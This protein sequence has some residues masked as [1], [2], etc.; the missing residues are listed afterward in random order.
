MRLLRQVVVGDG[1][2]VGARRQVEVDGAIESTGTQQRRV[3]T[4]GAVGGGEHQHVGR[5]APVLVHGSGRRHQ[6]VEPIDHLALELLPPRREVEALHLHE[7]FV[8]DAGSALAHAA[9]THPRAGH[10]DGVELFDEPDRSAL[11]TSGL[12]ERLEELADLAVGHAIEV[13]LELAGRHE[14]ERHFGLGSNRLRQVGLPGSGRPLEQHTAS[15]RATH[16]LTEGLVVEEQVERV[17]GL[18]TCRIGANDIGKSDVGVGRPQQRVRGLSRSHQ[19]DHHHAGD[20][21]QH[22]AEHRQFGT[23]ADQRRDAAA[24]RATGELPIPEVGNRQAERD[25]QAQQALLA[26]AL[27]RHAGVD[28]PAAKQR[29]VLHLCDVHGPTPMHS[30]RLGRTVTD[31]HRVCKRFTLRGDGVDPTQ[32]RLTTS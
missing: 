1:D 25:D 7:Q 15:W 18:A 4:L 28:L 27:S 17:D 16:L 23:V 30:W 19:R 9:V 31:R 14:Q 32:D 6:Q 24:H 21:H 8:D 2:A 22:E 11:G 29:S 10:A 26:F 20:H 3:E 12:A 13:R 5:L